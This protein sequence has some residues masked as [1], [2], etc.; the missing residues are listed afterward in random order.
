VSTPALAKA[1]ELKN[2]SGARLAAWT[3]ARMLVI[4]PPMMMVGVSPLKAFAGSALSSGF[5][6][7]FAGLRLYDDA[8]SPSDKAS[9]PTYATSADVLANR[10][11]AGVR[12]AGWTLARML[13]IAPPMMSLGVPAKKAFLGA[14]IGSSFISVLTLLRLYNAQFDD[15][16]RLPA[17]RALPVTA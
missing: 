4:A 3:A 12:L 13:L 1:L 8:F 6:S 7:L 16:P 10:D 11:G 2:G 5:I 17:V 15:R 14:A 9:L